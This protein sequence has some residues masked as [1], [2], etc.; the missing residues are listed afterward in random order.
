MAIDWP[1][2]TPLEIRPKLRESKSEV[3]TGEKRWKKGSA[4]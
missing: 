3:E 4:I 1:V 2:H